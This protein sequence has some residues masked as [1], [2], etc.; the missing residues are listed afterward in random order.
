MRRQ[1]QWFGSLEEAQA[2]DAFAPPRFE[3]ATFS[4]STAK[5]QWVRVADVVLIGPLMVAGGVSLTRK[6]PLWGVLLGA[7]GVGTVVYN[8]RNWWWVRQAQ[9]LQ[10]DLSYVEETRRT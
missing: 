9:R 7:L 8:A 3:D 4:L 10:E 1:R 2:A 6:H 5:A